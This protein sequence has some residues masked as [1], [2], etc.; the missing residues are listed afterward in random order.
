MYAY[1][2]RILSKIGVHLE[3]R[4][5]GLEFTLELY[6]KPKF[7]DSPILLRMAQGVHLA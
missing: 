3:K 4:T 2:K 1:E 6:P 7:D 5:I